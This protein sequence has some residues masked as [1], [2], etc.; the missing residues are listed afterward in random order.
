MRYHTSALSPEQCYRLARFKVRDVAQGFS[1]LA[2]VRAYRGVTLSR[3]RHLLIV[4]ITLLCIFSLSSVAETAKNRCAKSGTWLQVLGAGGPEIEDLHASSGYLIWLDGKARIL[5]DIGAGAPLRFGQSGARFSDLSAIVFTHLHVDH[6]A[7]LPALVKS[8]FL[9]GRQRDLAV[10][11]PDGNEYL[12]PMSAFLH[13]L[14]AQTHGVYPYLSE[15]ISPER[16]AY[17]LIAHDIEVAGEEIWRGFTTPEFQLSAIKVNHGPIPALA[18]RVDLGL[19]SITF[20]GDTSAASD[21]LIRLAKDTDLLVAHNAVPEGASGVARKLHMPPS[22]IGEV[23]GKAGVE[24]L[25]LSH[26]M[27]RTLGREKQTLRAI[28][29]AFNGRVSFAEDLACYET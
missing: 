28:E 21:N 22:R 8:S 10:F 13:R 19:R 6:S 17:T 24:R 23:A 12:P 3:S 14:F 26:R 27:T 29:N 5:V 15:Y 7:G 16:G 4:L 25:V 20:S 1:Q 11:G 18:W 2:S 9:S